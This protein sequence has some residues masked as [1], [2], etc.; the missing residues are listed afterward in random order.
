MNNNLLNNFLIYVSYD[1]IS[2]PTSRLHPSTAHQFELAKELIK[3]LGDL[4]CANVYLSDKCYCYAEID[5]N[6]EGYPVIGLMAHLDTSPDMS[7][8]DVKP[9]IIEAYDGGDIVLNEEL[10][11]I[12]KASEFPNLAKRVGETI[13]VTDGTTLLGADDKAGIAIIMEIIKTLKENDDIKH[14]L[15][16]ICFSPDEE[17]GEG[18]DNVDLERFKCD[19]AFTFDGDEENIINCEN[20]NAASAFVTINGVNIHPGS[21]K[22]KMKNSIMIA[23]EFDSL[24]SPFAR[25]QF[26]EMYEGFNHL[27]EISGTVEKTNMHYIIRNH[28]LAKFES[29][30]QEFQKAK[31]AIDNKYGE[32][33]CNLEIKDSYFNMYNIVSTHPEIIELAK[34]AIRDA[35]M[36]PLLAPIR[37]GTD[38][39]RLTYDGIITPNIGTGG[40][41]YHGKLEYVSLNGMEKAVKVGINILQNSKKGSV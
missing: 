40:G 2:D 11:V 34:S 15:V 29:Q 16:K 33:T 5:A 39:A 23:N 1:T 27:N 25:P 8:K 41:N 37:G 3:E 28:D 14:G 4:G 21:A 10:G 36:E 20:F 17:I 7:G 24:L 38:G 19:F 30:K 31:T 22:G 18:A 13:I 35:G 32:G 26:T 12:I 9:R 6:A